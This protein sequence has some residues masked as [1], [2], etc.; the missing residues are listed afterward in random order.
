MVTWY[1][2]MVPRGIGGRHA[3]TWPKRPL[4]AIRVLS[5]GISNAPYTWRLVKATVELMNRD[6]GNVLLFRGIL[7]VLSCPARAVPSDYQ[8]VHYL[9]YDHFS[10]KSRVT[11]PS[12]I[13]AVSGLVC[14]PRVRGQEARTVVNQGPQG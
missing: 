9:P 1:G 3:A 14:I 10:Q 5:S 4:Q 11:L 7:T 6:S 8:C 2:I 13:Y 12:S